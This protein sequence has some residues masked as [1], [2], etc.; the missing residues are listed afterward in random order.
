MSRKS[1]YQ[2]KEVFLSEAQAKV[3]HPFLERTLLAEEQAHG[4]SGTMY[5][6]LNRV[7]WAFKPR[8][9]GSKYAGFYWC[10]D[11]KNEKEILRD[12]AKVALRVAMIALDEL[13]AL[14]VKEGAD[15]VASG[16]TAHFLHRLKYE[17]ACNDRRTMERITER[18]SAQ[19]QTEDPDQETY[20]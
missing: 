13:S 14:A 6:V 7:W 16:G 1:E 19:A 11:P 12:D 17:E 4:M 15:M 2:R 18:L 3:L 5:T 8:P 9:T 10:R 20:E